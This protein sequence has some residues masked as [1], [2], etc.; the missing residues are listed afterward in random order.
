MTAWLRRERGEGRIGA[1]KRRIGADRGRQRWNDSAWQRLDYVP[2][3]RTL[4][5][6]QTFGHDI[7]GE[8]ADWLSAM[9]LTYRSELRDLNELNFTRLDQRVGEVKTELRRE[10]AA[11]RTE[12]QVGFTEM[13]VSFAELE[14]RLTSRLIRWMFLFWTGTTIT[15]LGVAFAITR[16]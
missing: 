10:I 9:D 3:E 13:R 8:L 2:A 15:L 7:V 12:M 1:D 5:F 16:L 11:L 14:S 4:K 6:Y